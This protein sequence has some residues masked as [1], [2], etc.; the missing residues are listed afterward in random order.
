MSAKPTYEELENRVM[1][2][3]KESVQRKQV[4]MAS[5]EER[6]RKFIEEAPIGMYT[7]NTKGEFKYANKMLLK[8][9][10]Y[11][12]K[13]WLNKPF[14]SIVH[15]EDHFI[16]MDKIQ[17]R[18][19]G[20]GT[21]EPY[22]IRIYKASGE[23]IWV[24]ITSQSIYDNGN[25]LIGMQSFVEDISKIKQNQE[26]LRKSEERFRLLS[27]QSMLSIAIVGKEGYLYFNEAY[28][29]LT[30]YSEAE[31]YSMT[32]SD[33]ARL[34]HPDFRDFVME[35]GRI[36]IA[37][38][39]KPVV[40][41]IYKG[42]TKTGKERWVEQ[43]SKP[44]PWNDQT[45]NLMTIIDITER[46]KAE[47][48]LNHSKQKFR[49][50]IE[51][52]R[53][54]HYRQNFSTGEIEYISPSVLHTLGYTVDE[55]MRMDLEEQ[56][57]L[58]YPED[59]PD[60]INFRY[61]MI[62]AD[63]NSERYIEREFRMVH[64]S[65]EIHWINGSYFFA[66]DDNGD[67]SFI[68]G[69]L[70]NIT[71]SKSQKEGLLL[72]SLV[73]DQIYDHVTIT[74]LDG[75]ISYVNKAQEIILDRPKE[76][77]LG[78]PTEIFGE[79]P[80]KGST[81]QEIIE[82]TLNEGS[83]RGE[84]VN[85][86]A[87]GNEIIMDCRTQVVFNDKGAPIALCGIATDI[88]E[89]KKTEKHLSMMASMLD[90]A[91]SSIT[92][93]DYEGRFLY[94]NCKTFEIHGYD[95]KE[96][97]SLNL[98]DIDTPESKSLI[99]ERMKII[100][101][102]GETYFNVAH[103]RKDGSIMPM[104]VFTKR[105]D[106]NGVPAIL[107]IAT[108]I[109][110]REQ[111]DEER[112][113]LIAAIEQAGDIIV[114]TDI[115]GDIQYVNPAFERTTGYSYNEV[116]GKN[117]RILKSGQQDESFYRELW[118]TI[119]SG[120]KWSGRMVNKSKNDELFTEDSTISP[121][122]DASGKIVSYVAVKRNITKEL[123]IQSQL[124]QAQKMESIGNLAG[125]IAHDFNNILFP[126]VGMAELLMMDLPP[127]SQNYESAEEIL[128]AGKRGSDLVKQILTFSRQTEHKVIPV[129]IQQ[130]LKE[131][132][133]LSRS[134]IPSNIE[135]SW[136]VQG[137]CGMVMADPTKI[138]Q[139]TMNL[140]TN[141]YHALS[142]VNGKIN[143]KLKEA[144]LNGEELT[145]SSLE[146][147][148]YAMLTISDNGC[149]I[150]PDH[151][152]KIFD[153]YFT[154]KE[155]G[156]G[157]GLGL[158]VVYGIIK[159]HCGDIK[160]YSELKNGSTFNVYLPIIEKNNENGT[161]QKPDIYQTGNERILLVDDDESTLLVE[162]K[163]L[164]SL[165]YHVEERRSSTDAL[166]AFKANPDSFDLVVTDMTMPNMTGDQLAR[167]LISIRPDIPIV[168]CTGFSERI[169]QEKALAAGIKGFLMKPVIRS[170][171]AKMVRKVLDEAEDSKNILVEN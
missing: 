78:K 150:N 86:T 123:R 160:V 117:P 116:I 171:M 24:K 36:K 15:S 84:I 68:V 166:E 76:E 158:A 2:L 106:W 4:E 63:R 82:R 105:V 49:E 79:D 33:T 81:Q 18:M 161:V 122:Q 131:V 139:I 29:K 62:D 57:T 16:V 14:H 17:K 56:K 27:E 155:Q 41:Y 67:P 38:D 55:V 121:I 134:T 73:M 6:Y 129:R 144:D 118:Q 37:G 136:D 39:A 69:T 154:T 83:W 47:I 71:E 20:Y 159:E 13:D 111:A 162:I 87:S 97:L 94:S 54:I 10:G 128:K 104:E 21:V 98:K 92:V 124:H 152:D 9:T 157:T 28:L 114:I 142:S 72:F 165:G 31:L 167:E 153:P 26:E 115:K 110:E 11:E 95:A 138:H 5:S 23:I 149:G 120:R 61:D 133:K 163:M 70:R 85:F 19:D 58:F 132:L 64:K 91:P 51:S 34:I 45:V 135:I 80:E 156:K 32:L 65:G 143:I 140:I 88:T 75:V 93:H 52:T 1:E 60:L 44:I 46:K 30:E 107:S 103:I 127:D 151:M 100:A 102:K 12:E 90:T 43:Y 137:D 25:Q 112:G 113:R 170:D 126:I 7:I 66:K 77:L 3:E 40:H 169:N 147:R 148:R 146:P 53:D 59:L 108:D 74:D 89:R 99:E 42:I 130:I 125:G 141:A 101:E 109:T 145:G 22:D 164:E 50:I 48:E 8:I 119:S 35:Q 96:F 168:I